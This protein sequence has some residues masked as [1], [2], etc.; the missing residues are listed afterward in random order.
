MLYIAK[1]FYAVRK[2]NKP[3]IY[4]TWDECKFNVNKFSGAEF[5][6][7]ISKKEAEE[8]MECSFV[9][10]QKE[11]LKEIYKNIDTKSKLDNIAN[12][13]VDGS[14][15]IKT[16]TYGYGGFI[17]Y[18]G[19]KHIVQG[20]GNEKQM[21]IMRNVAGEILGSMNA[22]KKAIELSI[23]EINIHYDYLGIEMWATDI[24]RRNKKET[25]DYYDFIVL[26]NEKIKINFVKVLAHSGVGG[27]EEADILAK[28]AVGILI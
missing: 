26:A 21:A 18:N 24:W 7:F 15:N 5:H 23:K 25:K 3:G 6:S 27:N 4:E 1:K 13:Y 12:S 20:S 16:M 17:E 9:S 28:Q 19:E 22:I 11:E 14:F 2:G 10:K 8:Y